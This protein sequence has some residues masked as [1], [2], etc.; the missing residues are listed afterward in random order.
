MSK[1][2]FKD[3]TIVT[4]TR[5][6]YPLKFTRCQSVIG[7]LPTGDYAVQNL[8]SYLC[9]ERKSLPDLVACCCS[10][11]RDRFEAELMRMKAYRF[12]Y[13]IVEATLKDI[14][15]GEYRSK[16]NPESVVGSILSFSQRYDVM[17]ILAGDK[18]QAA[19][20][21]EHLALMMVRRLDETAKALG[22]VKK[23]EK[24]DG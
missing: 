11:Q 4:D 20:V 3:I 19:K 16:A 5:E 24:K 9:V 12:K 23:K 2:E 1:R 18:D 22:Y 8:E 15:T 13:L 21:V 10:Q 7:T 17:P 6:Q 14:Y